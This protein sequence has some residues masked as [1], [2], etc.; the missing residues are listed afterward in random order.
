MLHLVT[1]SVIS[2]ALLNCALTLIVEKPTTVPVHLFW[3]VPHHSCTNVQLS[4][5]NYI[6]IVKTSVSPQLQ[7]SILIFKYF[8]VTKNKQTNTNCPKS[9]DRNSPSL[10]ALWF[11]SALLFIYMPQMRA[12]TYNLIYSVGQARS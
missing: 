8:L 6:P 4:Q 2:L 9:T 5:P 12:N 11:S 10:V 7:I 3:W 1:C